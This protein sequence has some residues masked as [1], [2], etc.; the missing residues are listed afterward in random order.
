MMELATLLQ[1]RK[2]IRGNDPF[3]HAVAKNVFTGPFYALLDEAMKAILAKGLHETHVDNCFS[4]TITGYDAY[5]LGIDGRTPWPLSLFASL[6]WHNL[7]AAMF[8][9]PGTRQINAGA[10]HHIPGSND[11]FI[12][13]DFN[14][15]FF[16]VHRKSGI[17]FQ[18]GCD[19][20][21]GEGAPEKVEVVR[22]VAMIFFLANDGWQQ[23]EGGETGL[24][25]K[26]S[27]TVDAPGILVPPENNSL[28]MFECTPR[29]WHSFLHN[30]RVS[31]TS[32]IMWTH[33]T[34]KNALKQWP[35]EKLE[36]WNLAEH[37]NL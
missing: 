15:V 18:G 28:V 37:N 22:A 16:P 11:G 4:R 13:N 9:I 32:I 25:D 27:P 20:K 26:Y 6:E 35:A 10:H 31:R 2:W 24:F 34:M 7:L 29:S 30:P 5:G 3:R 21:S 14:P 8:G 1:N 19:Y 36:R 12:H 23:G 33:R 17:G